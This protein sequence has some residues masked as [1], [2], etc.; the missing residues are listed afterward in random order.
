[1]ALPT[2]TLPCPE[3][4][5]PVEFEEQSQHIVCI[6]CDS[7]LR[8]AEDEEENLLLQVEPE[9]V[10]VEQRQAIINN[11]QNRLSEWQKALDEKRKKLTKVTQEMKGQEERE[12]SLLPNPSRRNGNIAIISAMVLLGV[13]A[14]NLL[15][16]GGQI[17]GLSIF[18]V[19]VFIA[20]MAW[21][22]FTFFSSKRE[23]H[24]RAIRLRYKQE[25]EQITDESSH[26][27][28]VLE[29]TIDLSQQQIDRL[30]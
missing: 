9:P 29:Q 15:G 20:I 14:A 17:T 3:C 27:I 25:F 28:E 16:S 10:S 13:F 4:Q 1:M 18:T 22:V 11:L 21:M 24:I 23:D 19:V 7:F 2:F 8:V 12:V 5:A 6:Y 30:R 26:A